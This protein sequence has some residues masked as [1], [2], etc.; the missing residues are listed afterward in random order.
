M[1]EGT[2]FND[3]LAMEEF[4]MEIVQE[5]GRVQKTPVTR[6]DFDQF[7]D[8]MLH[9]LDVAADDLFRRMAVLQINDETIETL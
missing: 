4:A 1:Y 3:D 8:D 5:W 6:A 7:R 9:A 2:I